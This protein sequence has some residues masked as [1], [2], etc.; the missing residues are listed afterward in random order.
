MKT[1]TTKP[2]DS[3]GSIARKFGMPSWKY[4][5]QLNKDKIS[6]N[7]D[8][9]AEGTVLKIPQWDSTSGDEKIKAKGADPFK[10]TGGLRYAY[11]WVPF[12][13]SIINKDHQVIPEFTEARE[14]VL[15]NRKTGT[16]IAKTEIKKAD[17]AEMLVPDC[18]DIEIGIKGYPLKI[19]GVAHYH[20]D[21]EPGTAP[22]TPL[23]EP[24]GEFPQE[25]K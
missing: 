24:Q 5:Y 17:D 9:L 6:D 23:S 4:L 13:L 2:N 16:I 1:Y 19:N 25:D 18:N 11:P 22:L 3:L 12:S 20:P 7:P 14:L 21:D 8:L 10:Y 15:R